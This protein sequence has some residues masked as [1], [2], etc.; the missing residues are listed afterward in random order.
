MNED[1]LPPIARSPFGE[2]FDAMGRSAN[3][4][5]VLPRCGDCGAWI[6]PVQ[7]F[8]RRCLGENL[9]EE[10]IAEALGTLVSWTRLQT[11]LEPWFRDRMP[12]DIGLVRLDAG[13]N[14]IA[15][16]GEGLERRIGE[17][18]RVVTVKDAADRCVFVALDP[19]RDVPGG[20]TLMLEDFVVAAS[21]MTR[22]EAA[23]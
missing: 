10:R 20:R 4:G 15:H 19:S 12:W 7:N 21:P 1:P 18:A 6:Y 22:D 23:D 16:L 2:I 5:I 13:P 3:G 17:R 11:S 14:V 9:H 8:C